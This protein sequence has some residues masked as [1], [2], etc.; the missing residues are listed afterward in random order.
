[1]GN[2]AVYGYDDGQL[3]RGCELGGL[4]RRGNGEERDVERHGAEAERAR[5]REHRGEGNGRGRKPGRGKHKPGGEPR[6]G[7]EDKGAGGAHAA[8][9]GGGARGR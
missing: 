3:G 6:G 9:A 2:E 5:K 8:H 4:R 7:G 1:M